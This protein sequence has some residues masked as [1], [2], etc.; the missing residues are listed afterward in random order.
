LIY[1]EEYDIF[2]MLLLS[3]IPSQK[4]PVTF[5]EHLL[6]EIRHILIQY[7]IITQLFREHREYYLWDI[8]TRASSSQLRQLRYLALLANVLV[9]FMMS[10]AVVREITLALKA[11]KGWSQ[12]LYGG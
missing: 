9:M 7:I 2:V 5:E 6:N 4:Y 3:C 1:A 8:L 12:Y 11:L 10:S